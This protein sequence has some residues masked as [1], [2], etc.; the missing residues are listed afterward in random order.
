MILAGDVG[1]TKT[2][3][4]SFDVAD[5]RVVRRL[6]KRYRNSEYR[7]LLAIIQEFR[8]EA[9][10]TIDCAA[11]GVAGP[12]VNGRC[13]ATNLPWVVD[14]REIASTLGVAQVGLINDLEATAYGILQLQET[15]TLGLNV[16][17]AAPHGTMA[18]IAA[19]TGLGEG[20]LIWNGTRYQALASEGGHTDFAP[21]NELEI[22]LLRY[23]LSM[24]KRVS[25]ERV[26]SGMGI[27]N[28]YRFFRTRLGTPEPKWLKDELTTGDAASAIATAALAGKDEAC[29][30]AMDLF[31]SLYGAEAGNLAL[32]LLATGGVYVAGGIAPKILPL[33]QQSTFMDAFSEKGRLSALVKSMPVHVVLNDNAALYG[34]A[35][36]A[37]TIIERCLP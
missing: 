25:Y 17:T 35:H 16:G 12:V 18:V 34:A 19:G 10:M 4:A 11:F 33:L 15:D 8:T 30:R 3:I 22:D 29:R 32:K 26:V 1:G 21:R 36:F 14:A 31:V 23:L 2:N 27:V 24:Y 7:S 20:G 5:G 28:L 37:S 9:G 6:V 13:E